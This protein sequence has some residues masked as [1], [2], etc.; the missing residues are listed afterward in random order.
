MANATNRSLRQD[1][2]TLISQDTKVGAVATCLV[3]TAGIVTSLDI[4]N[5]GGGYTSAPSVVFGQTGVGTTA[6]GRSFINPVGVVQ[7]LKLQ[8]VEL[9]IL[10]ILHQ[11]FLSNLQH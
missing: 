7:E 5:G 8:M 11:V 4:T 3:T 9:N 1:D 10:K 2:V 6:A